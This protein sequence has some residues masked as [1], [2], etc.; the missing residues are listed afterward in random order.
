MSDREALERAVL[1]QPDDTTA[2]L[3]FA[4]LLD[5]LGEDATAYAHRWLAAK[6]LWPHRRDFYPGRNGTLGR[7]VPEK[8][9]WAWYPGERP[10]WWYTN[11]KIPAHAVL[12]RVVFLANRGGGDHKLFSSQKNAVHWIVTALEILRVNYE[13]PTLVG[14]S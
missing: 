13:L 8:F 10:E 1:A 7:G 12:P 3:A 9:A 14:V 4:D 5:E 11:R 2:R 6:H